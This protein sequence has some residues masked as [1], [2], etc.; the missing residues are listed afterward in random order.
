MVVD[1][2]NWMWRPQVVPREMVTKES[3]GVEASSRKVGLAR[4]KM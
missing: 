1:G 2:A 3:R 4:S